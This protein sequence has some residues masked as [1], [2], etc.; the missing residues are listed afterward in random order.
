[1]GATTIFPVS[2]NL[3]VTLKEGEEEQQGRMTNLSGGGMAVRT[4]KALKHGAVVDFA[5]E[6]S[7]GVRLSGKGQVA[8]VSGEGMAGILLQTLRGRGREQLDAWLAGRERL[9]EKRV[10]KEGQIEPKREPARGVRHRIPGPI[11]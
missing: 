1:V 9:A 6:L 11:G 3:P 5:F 10:R 4:A 8:W 7:L 2:V